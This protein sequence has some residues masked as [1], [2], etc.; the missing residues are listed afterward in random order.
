MDKLNE[1]RTEVEKY[2]E[3]Y[4][5]AVT[6]N[7]VEE[8]AKIE[9]KLVSAEAAYNEQSM[10]DCFAECKNTPNPILNGALKHS[11]PI[12]GHNMVREDNVL[13]E[14]TLNTSKEKQIDLVKLARYCG[15]PHLWSGT[16]EA[17][18][19]RLC[20]RVAH[21][22]GMSEEEICRISKT[23]RMDSIAKK[24]KFE[25]DNTGKKGF[26]PISNNQLVKE[27]RKIV[28]DMIGTEEYSPKIT[29]HDVMYLIHC[30]SKR[31]KQAC[32]IS[33]AKTGLVIAYI[34][35]IIYRVGHGLKYGVEYQMVKPSST[36]DTKVTFEETASDPAKP[37]V[38]APSS[39]EDTKTPEPEVVI[40][41]PSKRSKKDK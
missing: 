16:I 31:G 9:A 8:F 26:S 11:Y 5:N 32:N 6:K 7:K 24:V 20:V 33:V 2:V 19:E 39:E 3:E 34:A 12:I 25:S 30:Y 4:S 21:E 23:Y 1:L 35:D 22:I 36:G 37:E 40:E 13:V 29:T 38:D 28:A 14:V 17:L 15:L 18:G 41:K 27:I 10:K